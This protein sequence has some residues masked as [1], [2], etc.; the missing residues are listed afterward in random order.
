MNL[1]LG[2]CVGSDRIGVFCKYAKY[3]DAIYSDKD[4]ER[5]SDFLESV[6]RAYCWSKPRT[7]L[8]V[9]C[10]TGNHAI[11][12]AKRG[13][14]V[15]GVDLSESMLSIAKRKAD[16]NQ[17]QIDFHMMDLRELELPK[18]FDICVCMFAAIGYLTTNNDIEK[19]L[20]CIRRY[21]NPGSVFVLDFWYGPAVL[22]LR[23]S[24]RV[25]IVEEKGL[26]LIRTV[27]PR[28]DI[29]RQTCE[30]HYHLL[31]VKDRTVVD[32]IEEVHTM[33]FLFPQEWVHYL[34]ESKFQLLEMCKAFELGSPPSEKTWNVV[35]I[36][37]AI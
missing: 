16:A 26:K 11:L 34:D 3:Y 36:A 17:V 23:P 33:R 8:D 9:G 14:E 19:A 32:D 4:Y 30:S 20:R 31:V 2:R 5:E 37:R 22:E 25:K 10:G 35:G 27:E 29:F 1:A 18:N 12:L 15:T 28:L 6:F 24:T 13:Y 7:I 21:L